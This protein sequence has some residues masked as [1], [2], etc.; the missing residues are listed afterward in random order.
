[1]DKHRYPVVPI[2]FVQA[3][4]NGHI[5]DIDW[6]LF[7]HG[8]GDTCRRYLWLGER[9]TTGELADVFVRCDCGKQRSLAEAANLASPALGYCKGERLWLG[10]ASQET[11]GGENGPTQPNR[12]LVRSASNAYFT[13]VLSVISIPDR[14]ALLR[15]AVD[16]VW[17]DFIQYADSVDDVA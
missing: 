11:C 7:T 1:P 15:K 4:I 5:S 10:A 8:A 17:D 6:Y 9:G 14:D 2:R 3:C 12:L 16:A 13:Q